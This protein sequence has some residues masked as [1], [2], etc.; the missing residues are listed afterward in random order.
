MALSILAW[1]VEVN[2]SS[3]F[4]IA[5]W[6]FLEWSLGVNL[7]HGD[8]CLLKIIEGLFKEPFFDSMPVLHLPG[9]LCHR[10][11][12]AFKH[13]RVHVFPLRDILR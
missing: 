9:G 3:I 6:G 2:L 5:W 1:Q 11:D 4:F 8:P 7:L 10:V 12:N 13:H